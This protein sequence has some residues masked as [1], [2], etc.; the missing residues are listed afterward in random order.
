MYLHYV[1]KCL[2]ESDSEDN[3]SVHEEMGN[4]ADGPPPLASDEH[5]HVFFYHSSNADDQDQIDH[6]VSTI[7]NR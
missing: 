6:Y 5:C 4:V 1:Q 7:E 2:I 3:E